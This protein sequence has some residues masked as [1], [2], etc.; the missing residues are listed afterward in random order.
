MT[1]VIS[2]ATRCAA[3]SVQ[4]SAHIPQLESATAT[5]AP[6]LQPHTVARQQAIE[7]SLSMALFYVRHGSDLDAIRNATAKAIRAA[8][9][10]KQACA[11]SAIGGRV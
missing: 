5:R 7:N 2:L 9:M 10:L 11:A 1:I 8:S 3:N 6:V 4:S